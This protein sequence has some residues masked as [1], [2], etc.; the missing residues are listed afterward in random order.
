MAKNSLCLHN[1]KKGINLLTI[2]SHEVLIGYRVSLRTSKGVQ[3]GWV[4]DRRA[5]M[6]KLI[7]TNIRLMKFCLFEEKATPE[8]I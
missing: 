4:M 1:T 3:T 5:A 6:P 2:S 7:E 8:R